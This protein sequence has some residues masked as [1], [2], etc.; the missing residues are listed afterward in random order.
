MRTLLLVLVLTLS[1]PHL[2][3][4]TQY[5]DGWKEGYKEGWCYGIYA[6]ATPMIPMC[7]MV[8]MNE[9]ASSYKDGYNRGFKQG[10]FD[11][12]NNNY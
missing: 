3:S 11:R 4:I 2:S 12:R 9:S 6:C 7:P 10:D 1:A 5:C 8:R